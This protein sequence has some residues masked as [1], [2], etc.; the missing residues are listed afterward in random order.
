MRRAGPRAEP[1]EDV[2]ITVTVLVATRGRESL[3]PGCLAS[4]LR[5]TLIDRTEILVIHGPG[6][7]DLEALREFQPCPMIRCIPSP[8]PGLYV[9]W[10][11]GVGEA[12]GRYLTTLNTDDRL[13][14]DA[15]AIMA[16]AL[17][18]RPDVA[19]VYGDSLVT[20]RPDET[21]EHN[22]SNGRRLAWPEYS[23]PALLA[24]CIVGPHPMWRREAHASVGL[25]DET[26]EVAGDYEF[27]LRLAE[28]ERMLHL[29]EPLGLY[30]DNAEG[31]SRASPERARRERTRIVRRYLHR[32]RDLVRAQ[33]WPPSRTRSC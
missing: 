7:R 13:R 1:F 4:L 27:W 33:G 23:L 24:R 21:F 19:L 5:Q 20:D 18:A 22:S 2:V 12:R 26:F 25:F 3:L 16:R 31:L 28:R 32:Y 15:L 11:V 17:D 14:A 9:A 10:N 6:G 8:R 30:Y 29:P